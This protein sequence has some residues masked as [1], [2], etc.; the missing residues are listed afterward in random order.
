MTKCRSRECRIFLIQAACHEKGKEGRGRKG[1][2]GGHKMTRFVRRDASAAATNNAPEK[3]RGRIRE[4]NGF[5]FWVHFIVVFF[6]TFL[7][8][9]LLLLYSFLG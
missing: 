2:V 1:R 7:C 6:F 9:R 5:A 8:F 3:G 4:S